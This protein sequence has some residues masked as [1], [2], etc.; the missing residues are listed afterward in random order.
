M[1]IRHFTAEEFISF[2]TISKTNLKD[3]FM[4]NVWNDWMAYSQLYVKISKG[5]TP[6]NESA[7]KNTLKKIQQ[8]RQ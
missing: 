8:R 2:P 4:M 1:N 6:G 5:N 7:I 3:Q